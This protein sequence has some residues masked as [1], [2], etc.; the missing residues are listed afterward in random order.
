MEYIV[1]SCPNT[2]LCLDFSY[3]IK[4]RVTSYPPQPIAESTN[5]NFALGF[6]DSSFYCAIK[7]FFH[8]SN[9]RK[10]SNR[11]LNHRK[12]RTDQAPCS[13]YVFI[14][15]NEANKMWENSDL[16]NPVQ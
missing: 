10:Y 13:Y 4:V 5:K 8:Y 9:L 12:R 15:L 6:A 3:S 14:Q 1:L 16:S 2:F 11:G 7:S